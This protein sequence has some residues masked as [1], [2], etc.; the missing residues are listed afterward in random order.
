[1]AYVRFAISD[2]ALLELM[3]AGK[4]GGLHDAAER[5]F[6]VI[7]DL[8]EEGQA[9][10]LLESGAPGHIGLLVF[11]TLQGIAAL[12]KAGM[13]DPPAVVD[14]VADA[15]GR[16]RASHPGVECRDHRRFAD[17]I[18]CLPGESGA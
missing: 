1:M 7:L 13:I 6:S 14:L 10:G 17:R 8:I 11:A 18:G 15:I 12:V 4:H 16:G 2:A 5:A 9:N 3:F